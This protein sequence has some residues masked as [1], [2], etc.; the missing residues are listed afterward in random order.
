LELKRKSFKKQLKS[1]LH[2]AKATK[3]GWSRGPKDAPRKEV[4]DNVGAILC[5]PQFKKLLKHIDYVSITK[6]DKPY[7]FTFTGRVVTKPNGKTFLKIIDN[8]RFPAF[9]YKS[10]TTHELAHIDWGVKWQYHHEAWVKFNKTVEA[11]RPVNDYLERHERKWRAD[12]RCEGFSQY[13]NEM[14]SAAAELYYEEENGHKG[15]SWKFL[16]DQ[17]KLI[18]AYMELHGL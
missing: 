14:H 11:L 15:H 8:E 10:T 5:K 6:S 4:I 7:G 12:I 3:G 18:T 13:A 9:H 17:K 16:E 2:V 1:K